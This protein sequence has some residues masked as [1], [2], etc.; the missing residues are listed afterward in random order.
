MNTRLGPSKASQ[1]PIPSQRKYLKQTKSPPKQKKKENK[2]LPAGWI[3][4][5]WIREEV[6][7]LSPSVHDLEQNYN[8][9]ISL[10]QLSFRL[11][12]HSWLK[13]QQGCFFPPFGLKLP[14]ALWRSVGDCPRQNGFYWNCLFKEAPNPP[15]RSQAAGTQLAQAQERQVHPHDS[16]R[17]WPYFAKTEREGQMGIGEADHF[18]SS[19]FKR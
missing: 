16:W 18:S 17:S 6:E 10:L 8:I 12:T 5:L 9:C 2:N 4:Y 19:F 11:C 13:M 7:T 14:V 3:I 1:N 15:Y